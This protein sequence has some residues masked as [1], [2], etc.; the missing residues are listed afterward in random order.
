MGSKRHSL[1]FDALTSGVA[2]LPQS[3]GCHYM[4]WA[5]EQILQIVLQG[6]LLEQTPG[7]H[8]YQH[9]NVASRSLLPASDRTEDPHIAGAMERSDAVDLIPAAA[10]LFESRGRTCRARVWVRA[11]ASL[12][13][14]PE[15]TELTKPCVA[16]VSAALH[17]TQRRP[18]KGRKLVEAELVSPATPSSRPTLVAAQAT[19]QFQG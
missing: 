10:Q 3:S 14:S 13:L 5:T 11:A 17:P 15:L 6:S 1:A 19:F 4:H 16:V 9:I 7:F 12:N 2:G 8:L 18:W